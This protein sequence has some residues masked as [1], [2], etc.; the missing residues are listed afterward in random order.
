[1]PDTLGRNS[2]WVSHMYF[3]HANHNNNNRKLNVKF[4]G[5][6]IRLSTL[7]HTPYFVLDG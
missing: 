3:I 1:M 6:I 5:F 4:F 2:K 7:L